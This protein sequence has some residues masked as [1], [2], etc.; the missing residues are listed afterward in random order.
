MNAFSLVDGYDFVQVQHQR[1][2]F[3]PFN[4]IFQVTSLRLILLTFLHLIIQLTINQ[5]RTEHFTH[6]IDNLDLV[7]KPIERMVVRSRFEE[8]QQFEFL[9]EIIT[10]PWQVNAIVL[11]MNHLDVEELLQNQQL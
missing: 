8:I 11:E 4:I 6:I 10:A 7:V 9:I 5:S 3:V 1:S 2:L